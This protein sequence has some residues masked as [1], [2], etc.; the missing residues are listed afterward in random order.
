MGAFGGQRHEADDALLARDAD[1]VRHAGA[2]GELDRVRGHVR[3]VDGR[4]PDEPPQVGDRTHLAAARRRHA[5]ADRIVLAPALRHL[6]P[7][8]AEVDTDRAAGRGEQHLARGIRDLEHRRGG[9]GPGCR[10]HRPRLGEHRA[11]RGA[12]ALGD[13]LELVRDQGADADRIGQDRLEFV[14]L[15]AQRVAFGLELDAAELREAAQPQLEDVFGLHL[16]QLEH[17]DQAGASLVGVVA[18]ADDLDDLVDVEDRDEQSL[19]EV[20]SLLPPREA[21]L[22]SAGDHRE[23][24][25]EVD[26]QQVAQAKGL[27]PAAHERDVVDREALLERG[28][29]VELLEHGIRAESGLDADHEA[30]AVRAV[31]EV[32]DVRDAVDLLR[33]HAVFDLLDHALGADHVRQFGDDEAGLAGG[34]AL[35]RHLRAGLERAAAGGVRIPDAVE[36]DDDAAGGQVGGRHER[37]QVLEGGLRVCRAGS[38]P[39]RPPRSGCAAPCSWPCRPR[40]RWRR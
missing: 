15:A 12:E 31:G 34:D 19:D 37:H 5:R 36:P 24:V 25:V 27:R 18:R 16:A 11:A 22:R 3:Q 1:V 13:L 4:E 21:E 32:G 28:E 17:V 2:R 26:L 29:P 10:S 30:Q 35:D 9:L 23:P 33:L 8:V 40:C 7:L 14:D 38:A 20:Q 6:Q 39:P